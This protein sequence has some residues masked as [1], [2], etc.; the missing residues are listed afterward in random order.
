MKISFLIHL[1]LHW[2]GVF[3]LRD[4]VQKFIELYLFFLMNLLLA[5]MKYS[6]VAGSLSIE[7]QS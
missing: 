3:F 1:L 4:E 5:Y 6:F 7:K 2:F